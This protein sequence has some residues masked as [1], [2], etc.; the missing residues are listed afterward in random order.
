MEKFKN[1]RLMRDSANGRIAGV[2]A[3]LAEYT[4]IETWIIRV[5]WFSGVI[6]SGGFFVVAYIAAWFILD[7]KEV[8]PLD[9]STNKTSWKPANQNIDRMVEVKRSVYQ[10][11]EPP[12]QAFRDIVNQFEG[13]DERIRAMETYVTSNEFTIKREINRL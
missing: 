10:V 7:K 6:F 9:V 13:I 12:R 1:K 2:C 4:N 11:G 8:D 5:I 3:G